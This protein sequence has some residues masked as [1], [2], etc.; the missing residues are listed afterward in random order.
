[1]LGDPV[2]PALQNLDAP[3]DDERIVTVSEQTADEPDGWSINSSEFA[4]LPRVVFGANG[5]H[6][7]EDFGMLGLVDPPPTPIERG[8]LLDQQF[9]LDTF[10]LP[11]F[12]QGADQAVI[13][14]RGFATLQNHRAKD[15]M[16]DGVVS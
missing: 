15:A 11:A 3:M 16:G 6:S 2:A 12:A 14:L 1:M 8:Q 4:L 13:L 5:L 9:L 10:R 7:P